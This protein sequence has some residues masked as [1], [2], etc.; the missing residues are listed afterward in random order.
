MI[1]CK[2]FAALL[3]LEEVECGTLCEIQLSLVEVRQ[4]KRWCLNSTPLVTA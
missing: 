4:Q 1:L 3:Y 2:T